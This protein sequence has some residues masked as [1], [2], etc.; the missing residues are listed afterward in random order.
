VTKAHKVYQK[1]KDDKNIILFSA[2]T[3]A[4]VKL[5]YLIIIQNLSANVCQT[6]VNFTNI[7][8]GPFSEQ[9]CIAQLFSTYSF[10]FIFC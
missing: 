3:C 1:L 4:I 9:K 8:L 10:G 2:V 5:L 6:G 7:L